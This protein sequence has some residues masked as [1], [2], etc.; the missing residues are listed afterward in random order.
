MHQLLKIR[1]P[2][3]RHRVP[4]HRRIPSRIRNHTRPGNTRAGLPIDTIATY[5]LPSCDIDEASQTSTIQEGV[6]E[7]EDGFPRAQARVVDEGN[8]G[9]EDGGGG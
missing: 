9:G 2:Q 4:P 6:Q 1:R 3:P 7:A 8:D 5:S